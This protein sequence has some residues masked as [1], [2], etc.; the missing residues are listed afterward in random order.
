MRIICNTH[1]WTLVLCAA[2]CATAV[3]SYAH[4]TTIVNTVESHANSGG[5]SSSG[6]DGA[7]GRDGADGVD[8]ENGRDGTS[9]VS[10]ASSAS[11]HIQTTVDGETVTDIYKTDDGSSASAVVENMYVDDDVSV[12]ADATATSPYQ[13][14][15][16]DT[17]S[18][19]R[20]ILLSYVN[21]LI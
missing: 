11:V 5:H 1:L 20:L 13:K 4:A 15:F 7:D 18:A 17:L 12:H 9:I 6:M 8:G 14:D 16:L 10:G 3:P 2:V 21:K 19:I